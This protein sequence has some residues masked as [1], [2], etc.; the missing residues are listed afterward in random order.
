M[1]KKS[2]FH[3]ITMFFVVIHVLRIIYLLCTK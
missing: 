1:L 2:T 3:R